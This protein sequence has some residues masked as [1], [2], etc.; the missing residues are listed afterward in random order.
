MRVP[1]MSDNILDG[2]VTQDEFA[3]AHNIHPRTATRYRRQADGL[4]Y[5]EF[6][7]KI[8]INIE[9]ARAWLSRQVKRPNK[10]RAAR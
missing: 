1:K 9:A 10:R 6:G 8:Y 2:Y 4:P 7:G 5:I 3:A